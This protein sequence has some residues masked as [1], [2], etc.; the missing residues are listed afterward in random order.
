MYGCCCCNRLLLSV[1]GQMERADVP[2][3]PRNRSVE[4]DDH[5]NGVKDVV[6]QKIAGLYKGNGPATDQA[7]VQTEAATRVSN[8]YIL[9]LKASRDNCA[10]RVLNVK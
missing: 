1:C 2:V 7:K 4:I 6:R 5:T 8:A 3:A 9:Q 10:V